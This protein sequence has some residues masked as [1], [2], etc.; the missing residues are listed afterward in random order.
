MAA[1]VLKSARA[2]ET[3]LYVVR[4]FVQMRSLLANNLELAKK[5]SELELQ[6][7][8]LSARHDSL[9]QQLAQVIAAIRQLTASPP[10][11]V[12]R[13]IGFVISEQPD[14]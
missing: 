4:A 8:N 3:S 1:T 10:S 9:A 14:K 6:T 11:P 5:L 2:I 12:K 7:V 13:P